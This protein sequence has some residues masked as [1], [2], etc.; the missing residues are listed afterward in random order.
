MNL[1]LDWSQIIIGIVA[2][3]A[4][5]FAQHYLEKVRYGYRLKENIQL[6]RL[7][8]IQE[9]LEAYSGAFYLIR[10]LV[11]HRKNSSMT[12]EH[13]CQKVIEVRDAMARISKIT[14]EKRHF[15]N[16]PLMD[17]F[18]LAWE[19][20]L[21]MQGAFKNDKENS[22]EFSCKDNAVNNELLKVSQFLS[23]KYKL[24]Q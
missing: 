10:G 17:I 6:K 18:D 8:A 16:S 21:W 20:L 4:G 1:K 13:L 7:N 24:F 3:F 5:I 23:D 11:H 9:L 22:D 12:D 19:N 15:V 14:L 2:F